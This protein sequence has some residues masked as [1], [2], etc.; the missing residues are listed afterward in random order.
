MVYEYANGTCY[1]AEGQTR[2]SNIT[3]QSGNKTEGSR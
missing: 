3:L 2:F 1:E